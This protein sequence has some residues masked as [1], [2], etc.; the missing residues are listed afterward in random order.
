MPAALPLIALSLHAVEGIAWVNT[1]AQLATVAAVSQG[2]SAVVANNSKPK[3]RGGLIKLV[4]DPAAPRRLQIG[5]GLNAGVL[6]DWYLSGT[7]NTHVHMPIYL[8]EGPCGRVTRIFGGGR[9]VHDAPLVHGVKTEIT[10]YRSGQDGDPGPRLWVTYYDGRPTQEAAPDLVALNQGWTTANKMTGMAYVLV[11]AWWDSDNQRAPPSLA[12]ENEGAKLYDRRKDTTAGGSGSH[13]LNDPATWEICDGDATEGANPMVAIDH[14]VLGRY[15]GGRRVFGIGQPPSDVPYELMA[16][17]AN[18]SD[19]AVDK[20]A[21]GTQKRYRASG[22]IF[23]NEDFDTIIRKIA[24][25]MACTASDF[26]GRFGLTGMEARTPVLEIDDGD[27]LKGMGDI[28]SPKRPW[29]DLFS[30]VEGRYQDT[31][32]LYQMIDYPR[33]T[34]DEWAEEDGSEARYYSHTLEFEIDVERAQRLALLKGKMLRRQATLRGVYP[35]WAAELERGDWFVRTGLRFGED[36]KIFEVL[37]RDINT[38]TGAVTIVA[39]EVYPED[40]AWSE[41]L[42]KDPLPSPTPGDSFVPRMEPPAIV[43]TSIALVGTTFSKP[44]VRV[45]F[46]ATDDPRAVFIYIELWPTSGGQKM[47]ATIALPSDINFAVFDNG[48]VDG[49]EYTVR[50]RFVAAN[51]TYSNWSSTTTATP[52]APFSVGGLEIDEIILGMNVNAEEILRQ[53][54]LYSANQAATEALLWIGGETVGSIA[55]TSRTASTNVATDLGLLGVRF[56]MSSSFILNL[57][58]AIVPGTG[59]GIAK[60]LRTIRTEHDGS[61]AGVDFLLD[62]IDGKYAGITLTTN[63][64]GHIVGL[65]AW[66]NGTPSTSGFAIVAP[67]F[68]IIDE[69]NGLS[70]PRV[71]FSV[72]SGVVKM[73]NVEI[74]TLKVNIIETNHLKDNSVSERLIVTDATNTAIPSN[75]TYVQVGSAAYDSVNTVLELKCLVQI[76]RSSA[77]GTR[78]R[79]TIQLRRGATVIETRANSNL[80]ANS[81]SDPVDQATEFV[82]EG[83]APGVNTW[84]IYV[85]VDNGGSGWSGWTKDFSRMSFLDI[86]K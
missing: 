77:D 54:L 69:A 40:S 63:V 75:N 37:D 44:A 24:Q 72:I 35:T 71:P 62:S 76:Y 86:K 28:Y 30:G 10:E 81:G 84:D 8:S 60:S 45:E 61:K 36:G 74:D 22:T 2:V 58:N 4:V 5:K 55:S 85:K 13:R 56:G 25:Q 17:H 20:K 43:A 32:N 82:I 21:G 49:V 34:V 27:M 80:F 79:Y 41:E 39:N 59:G 14:I 47:S 6:V 48:V 51:G 53:T 26:G 9:V 1:L 33:L 12:F 7:K 23:A 73:P 15:L 68:A 38:K 19:E 83:V 66:N 64:N 67:N 78:G 57:D 18:I 42:A 31:N 46:A 29:T 11:E 50:A 52:V 3:E 65:K 70:E 16:H